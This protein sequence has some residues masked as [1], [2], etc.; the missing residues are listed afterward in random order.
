MG[1]NHGEDENN[2]PG[3]QQNDKDGLIS[4]DFTDEFGQIRW[5]AKMDDTTFLNN[6]NDISTTATTPVTVWCQSG[7]CIWPGSELAGV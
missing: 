2:Q 1:V 5:H 4:P 7:R 6:W 3:H